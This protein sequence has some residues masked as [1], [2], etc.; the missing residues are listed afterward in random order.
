MKTGG[1]ENTPY[2]QAANPSIPHGGS[3]RSNEA[4]PHYFSIGH[5]APTA[6]SLSSDNLRPA[7]GASSIDATLIMTSGPQAPAINTLDIAN[8][9]F[10]QSHPTA[11]LHVDGV[12]DH[13]YERKP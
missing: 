1:S 8:A 2:P 5:P 10:P 3:H 13:K 9:G 6:Q 4:T 7:N 11:T 12:W